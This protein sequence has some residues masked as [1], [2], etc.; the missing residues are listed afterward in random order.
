[1]T[2]PT[3]DYVSLHRDDVAFHQGL[4]LLSADY[5][6][7]Y[8]MQVPVVDQV[9]FYAPR[10][11]PLSSVRFCPVRSSL[12]LFAPYY[13]FICTHRMKSAFLLFDFLH[14]FIVLTSK[15]QW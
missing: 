7:G 14:S 10:P 4:L 8:N 3:C 2:R 11:R 5:L 1:M 12:Q 9:F 15:K 13:K 6:T